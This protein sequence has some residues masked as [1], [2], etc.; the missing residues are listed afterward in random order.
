MA[1]SMVD[2]KDLRTNENEEAL[3]ERQRAYLYV[4]YQLHCTKSQILSADIAR[5]LNVSK[6]SVVSMLEIFEKKALI[7]KKH[8]GR[9]QMTDNGLSVAKQLDSYMTELVNVI[10]KMG[11]GLKPD[12]LQSCAWELFRSLPASVLC[13]LAV[14]A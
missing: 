8:Y 6:P 1:E 5:R 4:I 14:H 2:E 7:T 10:P 9:V 12:E 11:L 3:T 13:K